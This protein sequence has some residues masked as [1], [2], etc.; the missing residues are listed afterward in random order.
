MSIIMSSYYNISLLK[1]SNLANM[2]VDMDIDTILHNDREPL[3]VRTFNAWI[4]DWESD[5]LVTL[6]Q[7]N[8]QHIMHK[9]RNI[10]LLDE[11]EN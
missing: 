7:D 2:M 9:Y 3:H 6:Y 8:E 11:E 5:I 10:R 1:Y 4:E